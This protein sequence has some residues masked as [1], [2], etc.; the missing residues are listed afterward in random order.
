[1]NAWPTR[2]T[3]GSPP[4]S[5]TVCGHGP[6]R[7]DVV[8]DLRARFLLEHQR[9]EQR[10]DEVAGDELARVVDEEAAVGVAVEGDPEV[11]ALL[12][13]LRD[14]ELAVLGEERVRLVVREGAVRLEVAGHG[15]D[16]QALEH[17]RQHRPGHPVGGVDHDPERPHRVDVDEGEDLVAEPR[18][19]VLVADVAPRRGLAEAALGPV[20]HLREARVAADGER[21]LADDLHPRVLLR[22][23][24]GGDGE[25]AVEPEL[26][27]GEVEHLRPD[28]PEVEDVG[29]GVGGALDRRPGHGRGRHAHVA[30]D[31]DP[32]RPEL[33]DVGPAD[34]VGALLVELLPV[35]AADV[36]RLEHLRVEHGRNR[37]A[38]PRGRAR[39]ACRSGAI[40]VGS[41]G[42]SRRRGTP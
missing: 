1:M 8:D 36:V 22:V 32:A 27:D 25:A 16:R 17:R 10:G 30:A 5:R 6:A 11:G 31:G 23:V 33:L 14:D 38:A 41:R 24:R 40:V 19:D 21:A 20:A 18:P 28:H 35:E 26:A 29:P 9:R 42:R 15:L 39:Q 13:R 12:E 2:L 7:A 3:S 37:T 4:R 34:R